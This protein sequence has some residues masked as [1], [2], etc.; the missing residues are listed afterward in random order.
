VIFA[1]A[2]DVYKNF[3]PDQLKGLFGENMLLMDVKALFE[4]PKLQELGIDF[5]R[6]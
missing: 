2:H 3:T 4:R 5:W 1:A 6:L